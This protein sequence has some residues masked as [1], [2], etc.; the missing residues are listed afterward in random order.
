MRDVVDSFR[1]RRKAFQK[2]FEGYEPYDLEEIDSIIKKAE[3]EASKMKDL[4]EKTSHLSSALDNVDMIIK[5]SNYVFDILRK[6]GEID[7]L[8]QDDEEDTYWNRLDQANISREK[9]RIKIQEL[10]ITKPNEDIVLPEST[11]VPSIVVNNVK[12]STRDLQSYGDL[13]TR[14]ELSKVLGYKGK[15]TIDHWDSENPPIPTFRVNP[16]TIRYRKVDVAEYIYGINTK[17]ETVDKPE[18][19][20][21]EDKKS[22]NERHYIFKKRPL[23]MLTDAFEGE[24]LDTDNA[25]LMK[26][27]FSIVPKKVEK[28]IFWNGDL[29]SLVSFIYL[30]DRLD[31]IDKEKTK[32][33][34][35]RVHNT[36]ANEKEEEEEE[37]MGNKEVQFINLLSNFI[38]PKEYGFSESEFTRE[39][40]EINEAIMTLRNA[41]MRRNNPEKSEDDYVEDMTRREA[42][43]HYF[44]NKAKKTFIIGTKIDKK[45]L[46]IFYDICKKLE[47]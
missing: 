45:I 44:S 24:Y 16:K 36:S 15:S 42:I 10:Q 34:N 29:K 18:P 22:E 40:K 28:D 37:K 8:F 35:F 27:R 14:E 41:I 47:K 17:M 1:K 32:S 20:P 7:D 9:L 4:N 13:L 5:N 39:W 19:L 3:D 33:N 6:K 23:E 12:T 26:D 21:Q 11:T 43:L 25:D 31:F 46:D 30:S 38:I 2:R